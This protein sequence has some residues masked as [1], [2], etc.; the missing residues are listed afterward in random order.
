MRLFD[1]NMHHICFPLLHLYKKISF[2]LR[3]KAGHTLYV[4]LNKWEPVLV[5]NVSGSGV[6]NTGK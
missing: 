3:W 6:K 1:Y 4:E 5:V 2:I